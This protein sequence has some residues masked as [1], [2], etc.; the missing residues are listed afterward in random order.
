M[1]G[2]QRNRVKT[3]KGMWIVV[4]VALVICSTMICGQYKLRKTS[5]ALAA[6]EQ[7]LSQKIEIAGEKREALDNQEVYMQTDEFVEQIAREKL[8]MV[9]DNEILFKAEG[10]Q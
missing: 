4:V 3:K 8:G 6:Q 10:K 2:R 9:K 7:D 1:A 5:K